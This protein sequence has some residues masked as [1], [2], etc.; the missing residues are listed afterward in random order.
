MR[1]RAEQSAAPEPRRFPR[2]SC[3]RPLS[4][5]PTHDLKAICPRSRPDSAALEPLLRVT[6]TPIFRARQDTSAKKSTRCKVQLRARVRNCAA[7]F[8]RRC[9]RSDRDATRTTRC[10]AARELTSR[11][12][13]TNRHAFFHPRGRASERASPQTRDPRGQR[14]QEAAQEDA[15]AQEAQAAEARPPQAQALK[16]VIAPRSSAATAIT[17]RRSRLR[18]AARRASCGGAA[19][20]A[21]G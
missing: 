13:R 11:A 17:R 15:Q 7:P 16:P 9:G 2:P 5:A 21:A 10:N 19:G 20:R 8:T 14:H 12:Q 18:R 3:S 1:C 6:L 4:E